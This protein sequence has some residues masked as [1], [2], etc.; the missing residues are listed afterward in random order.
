MW[1]DIVFYIVVIFVGITVCV[2][3]LEWI[4]ENMQKIEKRF[5]KVLSL[6][7]SFCNLI[8]KKIIKQ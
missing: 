1:T 8:F 4:M 6:F 7:F 5:N 2:I 3:I